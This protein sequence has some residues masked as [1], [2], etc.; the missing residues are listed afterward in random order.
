MKTDLLYDP[1]LPLLGI[2]LKELESIYEKV[3]SNP[4]VTTTQSTVAKAWKQPRCPS[5][6]EWIKK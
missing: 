3:I 6:E 1:A 4:A 5:K 2:Y